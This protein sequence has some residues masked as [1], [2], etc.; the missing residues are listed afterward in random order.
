MRKGA[1]GEVEGVSCPVDD[2]LYDVRVIELIQVRHRVG[3][4]DHG[5]VGI[6]LQGGH[7]GVHECR[8]DQWLVALDIDYM[9]DVGMRSHRFRNAVCS[10]GMIG[11]GHYN[12]G[13]EGAGFLFDADIVS[14]YQEEVDVLALVYTLIDVSEET[15]AGEVMEGLSGEAR[16][17]PSGG[18]DTSDFGCRSL[19]RHLNE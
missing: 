2:D 7:E 5:K 1:A 8:F 15:L 13:P 9:G 18:D 11:G 10:G 12:L 4:C 16:G 19:C 14:G 3:G 17:S 6:A